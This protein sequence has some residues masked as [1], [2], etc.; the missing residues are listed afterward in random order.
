M[1][2]SLMSN[3]EK[4]IGELADVV[5][6]L[7]GTHVRWNM[8]MDKDTAFAKVAAARV[9]AVADEVATV[10]ADV[11][12]GDVSKAVTDLV[13]DVAGMVKPNA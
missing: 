4:A 13:K 6:H 9:H 10:A 8:D 5:H 7:V 2:L 3:I 12:T 1:G 11:E